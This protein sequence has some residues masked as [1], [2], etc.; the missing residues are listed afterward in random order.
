M[1]NCTIIYFDGALGIQ[2]NPMELFATLGNQKIIFEG[3]ETKK[4]ALGN[5]PVATGISK[6]K[7]IEG[8][9]KNKE[10]KI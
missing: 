9:A 2:K 10:S 4:V 3:P 7:N 5:V 6:F 1:T 8:L